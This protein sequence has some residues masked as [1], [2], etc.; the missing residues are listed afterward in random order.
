MCRAPRASLR[1]SWDPA[2]TDIFTSINHFIRLSFTPRISLLRCSVRITSAMSAS[3]QQGMAGNADIYRKPEKEALSPEFRESPQYME[4]AQ[5]T[6]SRREPPPLIKALS[7]EQRAELERRLVRKIDYRLLPMIVI[8]YIMNYLDRNNIAS[9]RL[10][11]LQTDL[12]LDD[13]SYQTAVSILFVGYLLMQVPSNLLLNKIGKPAWYLP[14][15]MV[16]WGTISAATSAAQSYGGL[17]AIRFFLGFVEAAYFPGCLYYLSCWYT[18]KELS[19]RSAVLY[20]GSLLSGAF[21]GLIAAGILNN[22]NGARGIA[23][24]RWLFIIEGAVTIFI[25]FIAIFILPNLPRTTLWLTE[26]ERELAV[27]RLDEDIG[28]DDWTGSQAQTFGHGFK[29]AMADVK[30]WILVCLLQQSSS[31]CH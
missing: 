15:A 14:G 18:R 5:P 31:H 27:W 16:V 19:F 28:E 23:A 30:T 24:W 26:E 11:G 7:P 4:H 8:M 12:N 29:L 25:A 6:Y 20:S 17:L 13:T 2:I 22:L 9:A 21:S 1:D 10:A 3:T